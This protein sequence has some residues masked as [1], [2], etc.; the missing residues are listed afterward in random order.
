MAPL[1]GL[2][3]VKEMKK[4]VANHPVGGSASLYPGRKQEPGRK[5]DEVQQLSG[6]TPRGSGHQREPHGASAS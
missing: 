6:S 5:Q 2:D 3:W 1:S 4:R